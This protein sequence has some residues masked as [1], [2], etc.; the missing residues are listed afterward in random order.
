MSA[1]EKGARLLLSHLARRGLAMSSPVVMLAAL[2]LSPAVHAQ[3]VKLNIPA[4]PLAGALQAFGQQTGMEVLYSPQLLE[5]KRASAVSGSLEPADGLRQLLAGTQLTYQVQGNT[6]VLMPAAQGD[7]VQLGVTSVSGQGLGVTTEGS[8]SYTTGAVTM[9][10]TTQSIKEIPQTVSVISR[11][12][13]EDQKLTNLDQALTQTTGITRYQGSMT[14]SRYLSRGFEITNFRVDGSA[15]IGDSVWPDVDTAIYD[16]IELLRGA[17]GLFAGNGEP[18]GTI[19]LA[20][21]RPTYDNQLSI[22]NSVSRWDHYRTEIDASGSLAF[23]GKLSGRAVVVSQSQNSFMDYV[24]SNRDLF[25]GV[26]QA[27]LTDTTTLLAGIT[28]DRSNSS[29]QAYGLP[30]Y[31]NGDDLKLPRSTY[32]AG[33]KD[34]YTRTDDSYFLRLEQQLADDWKFSLDGVYTKQ[35]VVRDFYNFNGSVD[36]ATG[37]G[38]SA[39]WGYQKYEPRERSFDATVTGSFDLFGLRHDV[40]AGWM[41]HDYKV[42]VPGYESASGDVVVPNIFLFN[43]RDY[44]S[45]RGSE[46]LSS[47]GHTYRRSD[48]AYGSLRLQLAEPL[49]LILGGSLTNYNYSYLELD[50]AGVGDPTTYE[51]RNVFVPYAGLTYDLTPEWTAYTSVSEIYKSQADRLKGPVPG[52]SSLDPITGRNYEVGLKGELLDGKLNTYLTVYYTKREGQAVRDGGLTSSN[53]NDGAS[54]CWLPNGE[55]V[56]KG[57]DFEVSGEVLPRL[58]ATFGYTYNHMAT[59]NAVAYSSLTPKHLAKLFASYQM[60]GAWAKLRVGAGVVAQTTSYVSGEVV[61]SAGDTV[62]YKFNQSGYAI[63]SAF[64][65]YQIDKHWSAA[66]NYENVFD[67][68][69]YS[70]VGESGYANFY[71]EPRNYTLSLTGKF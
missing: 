28:H 27:D 40:I 34:R 63:W 22:T 11:Q 8:G 30:R 23:D 47:T 25:Y 57:I 26:L 42:V 7:A 54:C 66:L 10:K 59:R 67:K 20:R 19:N 17:D 31:S 69:Y 43:P 70:T 48:G 29:D 65:N 45:L 53:P 55:A 60:P 41:W 2:G 14:S 9:G 56:S 5:G 38:V 1:A 58:Q 36:P 33:Y 64:A 52:T 51:D 50:P 24:G 18:G 13:I 37:S 6:L 71:G 15:A 46:T 12:R 16:H 44:P 35:N 3:V 49:H 68:T 4:Q 21:K 39:S 32:L 62:D 61:N